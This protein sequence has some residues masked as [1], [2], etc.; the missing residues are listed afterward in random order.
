MVSNLRLDANGG[1][2][3]GEEEMEL[4]ADKERGGQGESEPYMLVLLYSMMGEGGEGGVN[5]R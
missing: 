3:A 2:R 1:V 4:D 5:E